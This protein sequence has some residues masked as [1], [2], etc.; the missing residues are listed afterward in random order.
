MPESKVQK[1][2]ELEI[3]REK[4]EKHTEANRKNQRAY[5][6]RRR[7]GGEVLVAV[8]VPKMRVD[9]LKHIAKAMCLEKP[10]SKKDPFGVPMVLV[11]GKAPGWS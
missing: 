9:E 8:W 10:K 11:A 5:K 3:L 2:D 1:T 6:K 7:D 4:L